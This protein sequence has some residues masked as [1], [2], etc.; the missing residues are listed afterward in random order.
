CLARVNAVEV[1]A[2]ATSGGT[3]CRRWGTP[4]RRL[5]KS[6]AGELRCDPDRR[7]R[8]QSSLGRGARE[9]SPGDLARPLELVPPQARHAAKY[10]K[11]RALRKARICALRGALPLYEE[12]PNPACCRQDD[13]K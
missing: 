3:G 11:S 4:R 2:R 12:R 6:N 9:V 5:R 10:R 8:G 1:L 7:A 13:C